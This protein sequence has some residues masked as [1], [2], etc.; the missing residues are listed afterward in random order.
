MHFLI[1]N[2]KKVI[3]GWSAKCGCTHVKSL[4]NYLS[5]IK[6][7]NNVHGPHTRKNLNEISNMGEYTI[8]LFIRN[9]Y[10]RIISGFLEKYG[11]SEFKI[12]SIENKNLTFSNF[13]NILCD[14]PQ[15]IDLLHFTPQTTL[16]FDLNKINQCKELKVFQIQ[17]IDYQY[18]GNLFNMEIIPDKIFKGNHIHQNIKKD[19]DGKLYDIKLQYLKNEKYELEQFYNQ[20]I[21]DK[22]TNFYKND[23]EY[24]LK[25]GFIYKIDEFNK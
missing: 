9:P 12:K 22:I 25:H 7:K 20:D 6:T 4:F 11:N 14:T 23:F 2:N 3:F 5:G 1:N 8:I 17:D 15:K 13:V 16:A 10:H 21:Y 24:F 18:I 19:F